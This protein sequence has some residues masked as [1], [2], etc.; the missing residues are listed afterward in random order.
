MHRQARNE[1]THTY[2]RRSLGALL[3]TA[4]STAL[5]NCDTM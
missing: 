1:V 3:A 2:A 4:I 5:E